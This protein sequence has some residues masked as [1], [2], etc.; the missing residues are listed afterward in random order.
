MKM[1]SHYYCPKQ[2]QTSFLIAGS[3]D[4]Q[5]APE[6]ESCF[7]QKRHRMTGPMTSLVV[8]LLFCFPHIEMIHF[9]RNLPAWKIAFSCCSDDNIESFYQST[10]ALINHLDSVSCS[11]LFCLLPSEN[12]HYQQTNSHHNK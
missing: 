9:L 8:V 2:K 1:H 3:I 11:F 5:A 12:V 4:L 6:C 10:T 7:H